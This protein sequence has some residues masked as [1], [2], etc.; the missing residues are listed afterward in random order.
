MIEYWMLWGLLFLLCLFIELNTQGFLIMWFGIAALPPLVMGLFGISFNLQLV[1]YV[2]CTCILLVLTRP[3]FDKLRLQS[4]D[5]SKLGGDR[6]VGCIGVVTE[7]INNT[8]NEGMV[9]VER[10][11]WRAESILGEEIQEGKNVIVTK[12]DGTHLIVKEVK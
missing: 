2:V 5:N 4:K 3:I 8:N 12:V 10:E 6:M 9:R 7:A 1:A 11:S